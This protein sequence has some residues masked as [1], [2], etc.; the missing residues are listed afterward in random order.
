[1]SPLARNVHD[2]AQALFEAGGAPSSL[3]LGEDAAAQLLPELGPMLSRDP[4]RVAPGAV[5]VYGELD[6]YV[7]PN[8]PPAMALVSAHRTWEEGLVDGCGGA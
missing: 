1:M 4:A 2:A 8:A 5:A 6:V 7:W 3:H